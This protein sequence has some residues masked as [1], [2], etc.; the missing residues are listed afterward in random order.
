MG[1][2]AKGGKGQRVWDP[3]FQEFGKLSGPALSLTASKKLCT[4]LGISDKERGRAFYWYSAL[5][6][7]TA[8]GTEGVRHPHCS[9]D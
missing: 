8:M 3:A 9:Q 4:P 7:E 1:V 2:N 6:A 5:G